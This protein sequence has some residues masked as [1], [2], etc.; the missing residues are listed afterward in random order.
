MESMIMWAD[1]P[2]VVWLDGNIR[3]TSRPCYSRRQREEWG[4]EATYDLVISD[5]GQIVVAG[6]NDR[7]ATWDCW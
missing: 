4:P 7:E 5:R 3:D 1:G 6:M 2:Y